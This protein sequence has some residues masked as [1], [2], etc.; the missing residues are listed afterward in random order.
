MLWGGFEKSWGEG[1]GRVLSTHLRDWFKSVSLCHLNAFD[2]SAYRQVG[3]I[4]HTHTDE[5]D[6]W[7]QLLHRRRNPTV[8]TKCCMFSSVID[9]TDPVLKNWNLMNT[10]SIN[11]HHH[12]NDPLNLMWPNDGFSPTNRTTLLEITKRGQRTCFI[13]AAIINRW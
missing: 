8:S 4:T 7:A 5:L 2:R 11:A 12:V 3:S 1:G 10:G 9:T 13:V 6:M